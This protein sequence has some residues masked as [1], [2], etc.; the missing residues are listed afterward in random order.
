VGFRRIWAASAASS[1]GDGA[2]LAAGPLLVASKTHD[3]FLVALA[4]FAQQLPWLLFSVLAGAYVD[5]LDRRRLLM[6][7]HALR[8]AAIGG[9]AVA[10]AVHA[11]GL[12]VIYGSL[13][14]L[15]TGDTVARN[16][17]MSLV[18]ALVPGGELSAAN[19][20]LFG[21]S[22][23]GSQLAGPPLGAYLF[24]VA[25]ALPFGLDAASFVAAAML[26]AGV[27]AVPPAR[28]EHAR[29]LVR[30]V[31]EGLRWLWEQRALRLLALCICAMN[32]TF[33]AAMAIYVLYAR[34]RL[35]LG[36]V[37][38]GVLL[39]V[40]AAGGVLGTG[41]VTRLE[42]RFGASQ[43]LRVGLCLEAATHLGLA[44]TR[45]AWVAG[46]IMAVFGVHAL[47]WSVVTLS[48]RQR[49]VPDRLLGRVNGV[50]Y[51]FSVGGA[52]VGA[53]VGGAIARGFGITAP[54]WMGAALVGLLAA[55]TWR[56]FRDDL[57]VSALP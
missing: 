20:R 41:F 57:A 21:T 26:V 25:L 56:R 43:L 36:A 48:L 42:R 40:S 31:G 24:A 32:V 11:D 1:L 44:L 22:T 14:L 7:M 13:F 53:V 2:L 10:V 37:G 33:E 50:Y 47:V 55:V 34:E 49:L 16:A 3:P 9:L 18:P 19:A 12:G 54:F 35:G 15:G 39:T 6:A 5:R 8:A 30:E 28:A 23:L 52:A 27:R 45:S 17:E 4:T 46:A 38:Y 51:L 29:S